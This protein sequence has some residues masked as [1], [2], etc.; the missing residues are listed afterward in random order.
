MIGRLLDPLARGMM[1]GP[2]VDFARPA[3]EA[4]L[5]GPESVSWRVFRNPVSLFV[6]GVAAVILELAEPRVRSGVWEHSSFR[7]DPVGRLRRTGMAAMVTVYGA[8]RQA[9][10]MIAAV[11]R[12]HEGVTGVTPGGEAYRADDPELLR[13][14][15]ATAVWGFTTAYARFVQRL[16]AAERSA[17]FAEGVAAA[18]LYGVEDPPA[19]WAQWEAL[20]AATEGRLERSPIVEEFLTLMRHAPAFPRALRPAQRLMV[21]GAVSIVPDRVRE[22]LALRGGLRPGEAAV[23]RALGAAAERVDLPSSPPSGA[24]RRLGL[25]SGH[26]NPLFRRR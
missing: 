20:L 3:G 22:R 8:R 14:V 15:Q 4:A 18:R 6:G 26:L 5:V 24:L 17:M 23:L 11:R 25:P 13:W 12:G 19:S 1:E 7:T 16:G 9:E 10:A 2:A 21:R